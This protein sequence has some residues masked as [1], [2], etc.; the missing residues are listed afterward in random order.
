MSDDIVDTT[1]EIWGNG[2][3]TDSATVERDYDTLAETGTY[4]ETF[5]HWGYVGPVT[6]TRRSLARVPRAGN[7]THPRLRGLRVNLPEVPLGDTHIARRRDPLEPPSTGTPSGTPPTTIG[8]RVTEWVS[9]SYRSTHVPYSD[10][11]VAPRV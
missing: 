2:A 8:D 11:S 1:R 6:A 7:S 4:D 3:T 9:R 10:G 5:E